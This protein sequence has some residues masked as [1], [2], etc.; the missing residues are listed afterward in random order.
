MFTTASIDPNPRNNIG[1]SS[2]DDEEDGK[3]CVIRTLSIP[4]LAKIILLNAGQDSESDNEFSIHDMKSI[5]IGA[6]MTDE[7]IEEDKLIPAKPDFH[8]YISMGDTGAIL[9]GSF[10]QGNEVLFKRHTRD[11]QQA[12][13]ALVTLAMT[14][15]YNPHL[16]YREVVDDILK[17]SDK[18]ATDNLENLEQDEAED[19]E[20]RNYLLPSEISEDFTVGV[21][22]ISVELEEDAVTGRMNELESQL[23]T[24]FEENG[25][26]I[27]RQGNIM[28]PVWKETD[29]YFTMD[30]KG[31]DA[32]GEPREGDGTAAVMWY[33]DRS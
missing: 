14:K 4:V 33:T 16:W 27:F 12:A 10:N 15:L 23:E 31:R 3:A 29:V 28:M 18:V 2:V 32:R 25:M 13:S 7:E 19:E 5:S 30:P 11:K 20:S 17:L 26:G 1:L 6:E 21:N 22:R 8:N 24:F 9:L